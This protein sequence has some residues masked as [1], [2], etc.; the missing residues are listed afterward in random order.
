M[1]A[2]FSTRRLQRYLSIADSL[3]SSIFLCSNL[4]NCLFESSLW[5]HDSTHFDNGRRGREETQEAR[6]WGSENATPRRIEITADEQNLLSACSTE[7]LSS[8]IIHSK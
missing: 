2:Q 3:S 6:E 8:A 7:D 5:L 1:V 4:A